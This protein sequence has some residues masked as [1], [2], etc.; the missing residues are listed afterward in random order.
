MVITGIVPGSPL[1]LRA[2][3]KGAEVKLGLV[4]VGGAEKVFDGLLQLFLIATPD[5]FSEHMHLSV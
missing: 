4:T 2:P 1:P 5:V 3:Y